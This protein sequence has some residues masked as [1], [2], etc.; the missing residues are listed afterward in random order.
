MHSRRLF[1]AHGAWGLYGTD[2]SLSVSQQTVSNHTQ[3]FTALTQSTPSFLHP[4]PDSQSKEYW[5][6]HQL[7][8]SIQDLDSKGFR[9]YWADITLQRR[10]GHYRVGD[11][12]GV[13]WSSSDTGKSL[14][15]SLA[16]RGD[17]SSMKSGE[18]SSSSKYFRSF[19]R[20]AN[21]CHLPAFT[22]LPTNLTTYSI[23]A[24]HR[25]HKIHPKIM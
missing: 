9:L 7:D 21:A 19:L 2:I 17:A 3:K 18:Q 16:S 25:L 24:K 15:L 11:G 12:V 23:L 4:P 22:N 5:S 14:S 8:I 10:Y 6:L 1:Q 13:W 20:S